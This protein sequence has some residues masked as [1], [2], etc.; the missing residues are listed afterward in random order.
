MFS[1]TAT[2]S[3]SPASLTKTPCP[4][5][6]ARPCSRGDA[7]SVVCTGHSRT[8][9]PGLCWGGFFAETSKDRHHPY[10]P[11]PCKAVDHS[12]PR[13]GAGRHCRGGQSSSSEQFRQTRLYDPRCWRSLRWRETAKKSQRNSIKVENL[14]R[15]SIPKKDFT[16]THIPLLLVSS[17]LV[18]YNTP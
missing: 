6:F 5:Q 15:P 2:R 17:Q 18:A 9:C 4:W 3:H 7:T 13:L 14:L 8:W 1:E 16:Q 12:S 11:S 10:T